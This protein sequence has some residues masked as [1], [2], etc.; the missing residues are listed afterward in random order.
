MVHRVSQIT[1]SLAVSLSFRQPC[2]YEEKRNVY[3]QML[4][5]E[6]VYMRI[7]VHYLVNCDSRV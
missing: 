6:T 4:S 3:R 5:I 2:V 1:D 7:N